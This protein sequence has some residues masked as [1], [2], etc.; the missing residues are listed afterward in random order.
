MDVFIARQPIFNK[1]KTVYGYELLFRENANNLYISEDGD[2]ATS[3]VMV[4]SFLNMGIENLTGGKKAFVNF[5]EKFIKE[6]IATLFPKEFL[7]AEILE[8]V[9][10]DNEIIEACKALKQ[11]GYLIALDDFVFHNKYKELIKYADIIK[12]DFL[13]SSEIQQRLAISKPGCSNIKFLAEKIETKKDFDNAVKWGYT[14]FQGYFFAKPE[15]VSTHVL[16]SYKLNYLLLLNE[17][18]SDEPEFGRLT[19]IIESDIAFSYE[20]LKIV[21]TIE[22]QRVNRINSIQQALVI[23][24]FKE[25]KKWVSLA[26]MR[27]LGEG[28]PSELINYSML[29]SKFMELLSERIEH[30]SVK[31]EFITLGMF[32]LIDVVMG[33]Q[34]KDILNKMPFSDTIKDILEGHGNGEILEECYK[35]ILAYEQAEVEKVIEIG[36]KLN[37]T[38]E[39]IIDM[40]FKSISYVDYLSQ[41]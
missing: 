10:P 15:I 39:E 25:M 17:M 19:E 24:G 41:G 11:A 23:L 9:E 20:I 14:Y 30:Q 29:R 5:T 35:L 36:N 6:G 2:K 40:Y 8:N 32:S 16:S 1:N 13:S 37:L 12:I 21:N 31:S 28:K 4:G 7:V 26:V 22:Y 38:M 18:G 27:K 3:N 34:M 33:M